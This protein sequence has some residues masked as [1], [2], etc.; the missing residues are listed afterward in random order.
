MNRYII[1]IYNLSKKNNLLLM[2]A[3]IWIIKPL[4]KIYII[5]YILLSIISTL[6]LIYYILTWDLIF[7]KPQNKIIDSFI[8]KF[9][10]IKKNKS[11]SFSFLFF[12][13]LF[14]FIFNVSLRSVEISIKL[15]NSIKWFLYVDQEINLKLLKNDL[16][17]Y[18]LYEEKI[19]LYKTDFIIK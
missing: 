12:A 4:V 9:L 7:L 6:K 18:P 11:F 8:Y 2:I 10:Q 14:I 15:Y 5:F 17:I 1:Y 19:K 3:F 13:Y 16:Y